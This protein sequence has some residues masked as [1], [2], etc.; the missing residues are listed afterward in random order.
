MSALPKAPET[1]AALR[2]GWCPG[3]LR[4]METGDGWL[5]RLHPPGGVLT[6]GQ[7]VRIAALAHEHGNG[8]IEISARANLQLRGVSVATHPALV[9]ALLSERLVDEHDGDGPQRLALVSPLAGSTAQ[10]C[11]SG[12][13][14]SEAPGTHNLSPVESGHDDSASLP[15]G[16]GYG[17]RAR[18]FAAPRNDS[19]GD[20]LDAA[21]LAA[22]IERAGRAIPGL[23]TK[24]LVVVDGGGAMSLNGFAADIR[25]VAVSGDA[26]AIGLPSGLWLGATL[27]EAAKAVATI[28]RGFAARQLGAPDTICRLRD[29]PA[30]EQARLSGL[31]QTHAPAP[32]PAPRRVGL[33]DLGTGRFAAMVG[34]PFGRCDAST[35]ARMGESAERLGARMLRLSPWR[36]L[37]CLGLS[38]HAAKTWLD[39]ARRLGLITDDCD[40]RLSIQACAGKP[41][42]LRAEADAMADAARLAEVASPLLAQGLTLHISGCVKSCAHSAAADLTLVGRDGR[43]GVVIAG[44]TR[45]A[46]LAELDLSEILRRLQPGQDLSDRLMAGRTSEPG[47]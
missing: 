31:P 6:P 15:S 29:L 2:R 27:A 42:C 43:Y 35:L 38:L 12:A 20:F 24:T 33:F 47:F 18:G 8:L 39:E 9:E 22:E 11:H 1:R 19:G 14:R 40:A 34:L 41:A 7:I 36:G 26:V 5:V 4:P 13:S 32:R 17:F 21:L 44:T 28:L 3:T 10:P 30:E 45:D 37:A 16:G 46:A 23:Q 25:V